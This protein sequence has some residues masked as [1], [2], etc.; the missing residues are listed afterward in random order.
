[1]GND[2]I[3]RRFHQQCAEP[4]SDPVEVFRLFS[5]NSFTPTV[6]SHILKTCANN[7]TRLLMDSVGSMCSGLYMNKGLGCTTGY[8]PTCGKEQQS[9]TLHITQALN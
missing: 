1:M 5:P 9:V 6:G 4:N 7:R 8:Q 3:T 2:R